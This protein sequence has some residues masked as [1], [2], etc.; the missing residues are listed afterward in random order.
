M[1]KTSIPAE[2]RRSSRRTLALEILPDGRLIVRAPRRLS[3]QAIRAFLTQKADWIAKKQQE[4]L[5]AARQTLRVEDGAVW[6]VCGQGYTLRL[7]DTAECRVDRER[8]IAWLPS[9]SPGKAW[10]TWL[11]KETARCCTALA[12]NISR[13]IGVRVSSVSV[14]G[15]KTRWGSCSSR[16]RVNFSWHLILCPPEIIRY[17]VVHELCHRR[18]M[19]HSARFWQ[20]VEQHC[21]DAA[22]ARRWLRE[23][24]SLME[25]ETFPPEESR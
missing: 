23:H 1:E 24:R 10:E 3:V 2:I 7:T 15:A 21:P 17:V 18:C 11:R 9:E 16:G 5:S 20:L 22:E 6:P 25:A 4:A 8:K 14:T 12:D 13:E 19:D